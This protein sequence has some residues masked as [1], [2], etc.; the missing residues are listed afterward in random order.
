VKKVLVCLSGAALMFFAG[1]SKS[2]NPDEFRHV[3]AEE[4]K[5]KPTKQEIT[6]K[7]RIMI[8]PFDGRY[9]ELD[10]IAVSKLKTLLTQYSPVELINRKYTSVTNEIKLAEQ[11]RNAQDDL[12]QVNYIIFGK[13]LSA[14][15]KSTYYPPVSWRDK[16]GRIHTTRAYYRNSACVSGQISIVR[17][18]ENYIIDSFNIQDCEYSNTYSRIHNYNSLLVKA[19][20]EA[21]EDK[22]ELL[23]NIFAKRGYI[24]EIRKKDDTLILHTTLGYDEGAKEGLKVYIYTVKEKKI[25]FSDEVKKEDVKIGEGEIS[26]VVNKDDSWVIVE[27]NTEPVKIGDYVKPV[28]EK[29][30]WG[31]VKSIFK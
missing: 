12:G 17:I 15:T 16:K 9:K 11:A 20:S 22:K 31:Q 21:I 1:C 8:A 26:N 29:D 24:F 30:F 7:I 6:S 4:S 23:Y 14:N 5:Y 10:K 13:I 28:H 25:P 27:K 2:I 18:P 3:N 19:V